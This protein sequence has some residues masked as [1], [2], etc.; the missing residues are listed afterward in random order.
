MRILL[1]GG[2]GAVSGA[3]ASGLVGSGREVYLLTDGKGSIPA[4][5]GVHCHLVA[6]RNHP[7]ALKAAIESAGV[8]NWDVVVDAVPFSESH[9]IGLL[10]VIRNQ[11]RHVFVISSAFVLSPRAALPL[12]NDS[13]V[14]SEKELGGYAMSKL[15]M[16]CVWR[17]AFRRD[18][19]PVTILRLPHVLA[20]GGELGC[21]PL[22]SRDPYLL[23]RIKKRQHLILAD[24]GRQ[25]HQ[26][27]W[28]QDVAEVIL[29]AA[30]RNVCVGKTYACAH[31]EVLSGRRYFDLVAQ[32]VGVSC[33][34]SPLPSE[35][36]WRSGWGWDLSCISRTYDLNPLA[37]DIGW[38][39]NTQP[40]ESIRRC[41]DW[42]LRQS[43]VQQ[44]KG[45]DLFE[46]IL[47]ELEAGSDR[48]TDMLKSL[49][50]VRTKLPIDARMNTLPRPQLDVPDAPL[51][52]DSPR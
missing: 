52:I 36:I 22:H 30:G 15:R 13:P 17:E 51:D 19:V 28:G 33:T 14:G 43:K 12:G 8:G 24:G 16:E 11:S 38:I 29:R 32:C 27:V 9:A 37:T 23:W 31:P 10:E 21:I 48:V 6:E 25:V 42:L 2:T 18:G 49:D 35:I 39:P 20:P 3:I 46:D 7:V 50:R 45:Y 41:V 47:H 26:V 1:I 44:L 4:P 34:V 40:C 5:A